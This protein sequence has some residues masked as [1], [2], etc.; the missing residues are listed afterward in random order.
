LVSRQQA[1]V[2]YL[3]RAQEIQDVLLLASAK[4]IEILLHGVGFAAL[5]RMSGDCLEQISGAAIV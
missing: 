2:E 1:C 4:V 3:Q 5:T